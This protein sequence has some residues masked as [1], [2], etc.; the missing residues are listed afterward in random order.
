MLAALPSM[1]WVGAPL[2]PA[3]TVCGVA[4]CLTR[5]LLAG[6]SDPRWLAALTDQAGTLCHTSN[7]FHTVPQVTACLSLL[8]DSMPESGL[9]AETSA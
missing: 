5:L 3:C 6:H 4:L 8:L 9:H 7:L 2:L 1:H